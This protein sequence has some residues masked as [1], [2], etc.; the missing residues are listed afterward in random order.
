M[1]NLFLTTKTEKLTMELSAEYSEYIS[2]IFTE[3]FI[4]KFSDT[5]SNC[6][7]DITRQ[8]FSFTSIGYLVAAVRKRCITDFTQYTVV[9]STKYC[10]FCSN[11]IG[12]L[13]P[14]FSMLY[15]DL[16]FSRSVW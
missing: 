7:L 5:S 16:I 15:V 4:R 1:Q 11:S 9:N 12:P 8:S 6:A 3:D 10:F 2:D 14:H 13:L